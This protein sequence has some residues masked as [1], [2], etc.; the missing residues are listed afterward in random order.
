MLY[1][2]LTPHRI[3]IQ[4]RSRNDIQPLAELISDHLQKW[5]PTPYSINI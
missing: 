2:Y 1:L 3:N 4:P 5:Y